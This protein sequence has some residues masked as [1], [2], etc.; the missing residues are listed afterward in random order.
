V[1]NL[2]LDETRIPAVLDQVGDTRPSQRVGVQ[3]VVQAQSPAV[4]D[5]AGVEP[6]TADPQSARQLPH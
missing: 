5:E 6:L 4:G 1:A 2:F 3:A